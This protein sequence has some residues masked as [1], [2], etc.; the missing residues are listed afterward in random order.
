M[1]QLKEFAKRVEE[2]DF[3]NKPYRSFPYELS[4]EAKEKGIVIVY[5]ASDD[6]MEFEG[7]IYDEF[8]CYEGGVCYLNNAGE[9]EYEDVMFDVCKSIEA[10]WSDDEDEWCWTYKTKIPHA[11]FEIIEDDGTK[12]CIGLVFYKKD[13][14][15][16]KE[17]K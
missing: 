6:L 16:K 2:S 17:T 5:G 14:E 8:G 11:T 10:I 4:D 15:R 13:L 3:H 9:I 7:A 12:Y 1:E